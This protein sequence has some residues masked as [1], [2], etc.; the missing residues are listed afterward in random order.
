MA[1]KNLSKLF[2]GKINAQRLP[3]IP[4]TNEQTL[5]TNNGELPISILKQS[6]PFVE[7]LT[8]DNRT[9]PFDD[10]D[11]ESSRIMFEKTREDVL[12]LL[13]NYPSKTYT[14]PQSLKTHYDNS[15]NQG[16][17]IN[18]LF[19]PLFSSTDQNNELVDTF[20]AP[21]SDR[22]ASSRYCRRS[23]SSA[24]SRRSS[25]L[26]QRHPSIPHDTAQLQCEDTFDTVR[27]SFSENIRSSYTPLP[28]I[29]IDPS[30][31]LSKSLTI[32]SIDPFQ[33]ISP[34]LISTEEKPDIQEKKD[35]FTRRILSKS[36]HREPS[37]SVT[38]KTMDSPTLVHKSPLVKSGITPRLQKP[39]VETRRVNSVERHAPTV[40]NKCKISTACSATSVN[41][42][43]QRFGKFSLDIFQPQS[44]CNSTTATTIT[45]T[46]TV[47]N[48][49]LITTNNKTKVVSK[50]NIPK[51]KVI[52]SV[53]S[54]EESIESNNDV[55][56]P[57][58]SL[59]SVSNET[60]QVSNSV[61]TE[62]VPPLIVNTEPLSSPQTEQPKFSNFIQQK[63]QSSSS[64]NLHRH[65]HAVPKPL[66]LQ[67]EKTVDSD[68]PQT[69]TR[70]VASTMVGC[71]RRGSL[72]GQPIIT[73]LFE[74]T[75]VNIQKPL[76]KPESTP[77][78]NSSNIKKKILRPNLLKSAKPK[79]PI[80][81]NKPKSSPI[82]NRKV[83]MKCQST[84]TETET[85]TEINE[86][87]QSDKSP[88]VVS[89]PNWMVSVQPQIMKDEEF[90]SS[91]FPPISTIDDEEI[92]SCTS[93]ID[94]LD[95]SQTTLMTS[96]GDTER[97]HSIDS[98]HAVEI[99]PVLSQIIEHPVESYRA[100][101]ISPVL[102]QTI[103]HVIE[104][105]SQTSKPNESS[106]INSDIRTVYETVKESFRKDS[107]FHSLPSQSNEEEVASIKPSL[108]TSIKSTSS[109]K[110]TLPF[111][112]TT[113][114]THTYNTSDTGLTT[115]PAL[116]VVNDSLNSRGSE[117]ID[118]TSSHEDYGTTPLCIEADCDEIYR[119][120]RKGRQVGKGAYGVVWSYLT[121]TGRVIAVKEIELDDDDTDR[122]R[123]DYESVREEINILR[124]LTHPYIVKFLGISLE[125]T[126]L[127][128]IFME[129]LPNGTIE[130]LILS[131]GP[132]HNDVLKKYTQQIVE[133]VA[134]LHANH[135]VHR[136]IK[137]KNIML[138]VDGN[139]KLI[140]FGCAKRLKNN[141]NTHSMRQILK[142]MKGTA[143]WMA[144]EVIAET[145][146]GKKA[147]IWSIG[148]TLCEMATGKPPWSSEHSH[149]AVLLIIANGTKP[150][151]DLPDTC[152]A[153]GQDFFRLCLTRDPSA[154]PSAK[155]L[156]AH[157][158]LAS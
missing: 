63:R 138:D 16:Q 139:I 105:T 94:E 88:M 132:F 21:L 115:G 136:D 149:L 134:Y 146:H 48:K 151:A 110:K 66:T 125:N 34:P 142:S 147:D 87:N 7:N 61:T 2:K 145:G 93:P 6:K 78:T 25:I 47:S 122:L 128:K 129:Y 60:F 91:F 69:I 23:V 12:L 152:P 126:R 18:P 135:V 46:T 118:S 20:P 144:P 123:N 111:E 107:S 31:N 51:V 50:T 55:I 42:S 130:H 127:V 67:G 90:E 112:T 80:V 59:L 141:Q 32:P 13:D 150:P 124:A 114:I 153:S 8:T 37:A 102:T 15:L 74:D 10:D 101:E 56:P 157:P 1:T 68:Y 154:R 70:P 95:E 40:P 84:N 72:K 97:Q 148:C 29:P 106:L 96:F 121:I 41:T 36:L 140:D 53:T 14:I 131:F 43:Q 26:F 99:S 109:Y 77:T 24:C 120:A 30:S 11:L 39:V 44:K 19:V 4:I 9:I 133:G 75:H 28:P 116:R 143:N 71:Q 104:S 58:S 82:V 49:K 64:S 117:T 81:A 76:V 108:P 86:E 52:N 3:P 65:S 35:E 98:S 33:S 156:L 158:F 57:S 38:D 85:E 89:G 92:P 22:L 103:T 113:S 79:K 62:T 83:D 119:T 17:T 137:G 155:D 73:E 45:T 100:I 54:N 5:T 27:E